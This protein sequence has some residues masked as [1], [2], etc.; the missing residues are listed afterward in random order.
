VS[1]RTRETQGLEVTILETDRLTLR[2]LSMDDAEFILA[3]LTDPA[4][5]RY[6]GDKGVRTIAD[7]RDYIETGPVA[8]YDQFGF[9]L[10]LVVA[11]KGNTPIGM[12]GLLKRES[13]PDADIGFAFLPQ[14]RSKG[15]ALEA[16]R[17]V[18]AYGRDK[19]GLER[20][21]A[22][23]DPENAGSIRILQQIGLRFE[24]VVRLS[25]DAKELQLYTTDGVESEV[26]EAP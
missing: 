12:C 5:L 22:I 17:A 23:T 14:H 9:G 21:L 7:A 16:A 26:N 24:R 2:R 10:Y 18:L 4:F 6:I 19:L 25:D 13:L 1:E 20:I 8:S 3:L 11:K 15:Y